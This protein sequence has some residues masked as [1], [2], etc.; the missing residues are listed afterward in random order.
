MSKETISLQ[1]ASQAVTQEAILIEVDIS[2]RNKIHRLLQTVKICPVKR[3]LSISPITLGSLARISKLLLSM[4]LSSL[5]KDVLTGNY[6]IASE[7]S[8]TIAR[9]I[10]LAIWNRKAMPPK[11]LERFIEFQF[12]P[13]ALISVMSTVLKQ[14]DVKSFM[15]AIVSIRGLNVM[16]PSPEKPR[17]DIAPGILSE[18]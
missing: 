6:L 12:S 13:E 3:T 9:I 16:D 7:H 18:E 4:D 10:A 17:R 15:T 5:N 11:S 2:P 14:M 8:G 1:N